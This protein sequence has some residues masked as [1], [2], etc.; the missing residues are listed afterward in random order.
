MRAFT[1]IALT[2]QTGKR[3]TNSANQTLSFKYYHDIIVVS[4]GCRARA[5]YLLTRGFAEENQY[6]F[7]ICYSIYPISPWLFR[8]IMSY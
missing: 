2:V 7:M 5:L 6:V 8:K 1:D 4:L 3:R